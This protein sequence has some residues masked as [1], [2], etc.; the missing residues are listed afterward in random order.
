MT[1]NDIQIT[2]SLRIRILV[3]TS[4]TL[5]PSRNS[6]RALPEKD[7]KSIC[8]IA[9]SGR[10]V[11]TIGGTN[12]LLHAASTR[13]RQYNKS[14]GSLF[15]DFSVGD[16]FVQQFAVRVGLLCFL[17]LYNGPVDIP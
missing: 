8:S 2:L 4:R 6:M 7:S 16:L 15:I 13:G 9:S 1:E 17:P 5:L 11:P 3:F 14:L 12:F 10:G